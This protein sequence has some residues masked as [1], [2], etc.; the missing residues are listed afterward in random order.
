MTFSADQLF[1]STGINMTGAFVYNGVT[2]SMDQSLSTGSYVTFQGI[3]TQML[4]GASAYINSLTGTNINAV[5]ITASSGVFNSISA[6]TGIFNSITYVNETI[7]NS[8]TTNLTVGHMTG[9]LAYIQDLN[10]TGHLAVQATGSISLTGDAN[11]QGN[12]TAQNASVDNLSV[13]GGASIGGELT[14]GYNGM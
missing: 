7:V 5:N 13:N 2:V 11:I 9:T 6:N 8:S 10:V 12:F 14:V 3:T 4:T 1:V